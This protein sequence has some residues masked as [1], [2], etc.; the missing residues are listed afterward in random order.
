MFKA[1]DRI[2]VTGTS[3]GARLHRRD[4]APRLQRLP[5]QPRNPRV[6]PPRRLD[7]QPLLSG[8]CLQGQAHGRAERQRARDDAEPGQSSVFAPRRTSCWCAARCP[9]PQRHR[10]APAGGEGGASWLS[11]LNV[12]LRSQRNEPLG[13][14]DLPAEVFRRPVRRHLLY[15]AVK[16]QQ[17]NRRAGTRVDQDAGLRQRRR[18]EAVAPEGHRSGPR[19]KQPLA[20]LGRRCDDLRAA[21]ARL[22]VSHAGARRGA[23]RCSRHWRSRRA[24]ASSWCSTRSSWRRRRPSRS[25]SLLADLGLKSALIVIP[26]ARPVLRR[27]RATCARSRCCAPRAPTSTTCCATSTWW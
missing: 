21:A 19:R 18:Q 11:A 10:R 27:R 4:Q 13:E 12:P 5:G 25:S 17:A 1:G 22:L 23:P 14:F 6:L 16:M 8:A 3:Q 24:R 2:D 20:H 7:R 9:E 26:A 15:E